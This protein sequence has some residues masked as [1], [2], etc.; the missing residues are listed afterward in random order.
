MAE[1]KY[2]D[3]VSLVG[4]Y[5][6]SKDFN[7]YCKKH[8][9]VSLRRNARNFLLKNGFYDMLKNYRKTG[10]NGFSDIVKIAKEPWL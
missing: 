9:G 10:F 2:V 6:S 5:C 4:L 7:L 3:Y 8:R 1:K